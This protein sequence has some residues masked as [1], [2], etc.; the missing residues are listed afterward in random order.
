MVRANLN[1]KDSDPNLQVSP[2]R[3]RSLVPNR[4]VVVT[5]SLVP[6]REVVVT[7]SDE[8]E[9]QEQAQLAMVVPV[10]KKTLINY[11]GRN[12]ALTSMM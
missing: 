9:E 4:E 12:A 7:D 11:R 1:R 2:R 8:E 5:R 10:V 6:N 3:P